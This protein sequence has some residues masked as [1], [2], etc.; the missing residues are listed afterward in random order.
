MST[1]DFVSNRKFLSNL[2]LFLIDEYRPFV[3]QDNFFTDNT[4]FDVRERRYLIHY[5]EHDLFHDGPQ[6]SGAGLLLH[7]IFRDTTERSFGKG[8]LDVLQLKKSLVLLND[9]VSRPL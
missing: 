6:T 3:I 9:S 1:N 8:K 7:G 4:F 5:I 2:G